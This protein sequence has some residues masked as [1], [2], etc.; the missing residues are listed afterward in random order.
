MTWAR[1]EIDAFSWLH[2]LEWADVESD[3][4]PRRAPDRITVSG[5]YYAMQAV[6]KPDDREG[7]RQRATDCERGAESGAVDAPTVQEDPNLAAVVTAW[8]RLSDHI[9]RTI[10]TLVESD[11]EQR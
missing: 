8:P 1:I 6:P 10:Q 2:L 3:S 4:V 7:L 11:H 9:R 5:K